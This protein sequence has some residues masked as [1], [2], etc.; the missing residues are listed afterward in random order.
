MH[1]GTSKRHS[2][3]F[4]GISFQIK[5]SVSGQHDARVLIFIYHIVEVTSSSDT[6][7]VSGMLGLGPNRGSRI[8]ASLNSQPQGD[9][10]L[11]R[12]F[13]QNLSAPNILTVLLGRSNDPAEKYPGS[14]TV[15]ESLQGL[16]NI[17]SQPREPVTALQPPDSPNQ[18][19]QVLL[20]E[21]GIIGPD[22][23]PIQVQTR[24][25]G[26]QNPKQL[27]AV[28]DTGFSFPQV[29]QCVESMFS[30]A[31]IVLTM[32]IQREVS[33]A[34]YSGI[35]GASL[36]S[37]EGLGPIWLIPCDAEINIAFKFGGQTYP[38]HPLDTN[39]DDALTNP[40]GRVCL[41]AVC[42]VCGYHRHS[43][44]TYFSS[45]PYPPARPHITTSF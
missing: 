28:F 3:I 21:D 33:S 12:I 30:L 8:H 37:V 44:S 19:W 27:T 11:D 38:I 5:R 15:G 41:G 14:I 43:L 20:D 36:Q 24:V 10:V 17:T 13:Q 6:P 39:S 16:E 35:P 7:P 40:D 29:P 32:V 9:T 18:H 26:T 2:W 31:C 42:L 45:S 4:W 1:Q 23:Q 34:I 25:Q 22:G